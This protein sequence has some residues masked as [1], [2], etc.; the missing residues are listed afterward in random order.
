MEKI[1][2][3]INGELIAPKG[4][5]FREN[6]NPAIGKPFSLVPESNRDDFNLALKSAQAAYPIWSKLS[7]EERSDY[8][9][10]IANLIADKL[11]E[12]ALAEST[13]T[14]KPLSLA[15]RVDIPRASKNFK[16]FAQ[17][18]TQFGSESYSNTESINYTLRQPLGVVGCISPWNLPLYLFSWKIAPALAAGNCVIAKPSELTPYTAFLLSKICI[19]IGLPAGVLNI[20]H[21]TGASIGNEIVTSE[22]VKA[23]SFTGGTVTGKKIAEI[24]A[25]MLRKIS[26]ELGGKNAA[27]VFND[28][29]FDK[30]VDDLVR[31]SFTNQGEICLCASRIY[32]QEDIYE[33]FK[34]AFVERVKRLKVGDPRNA[35]TNM[36]ALISKDHLEKVKAFI[37]AAHHEGG[38]LLCGNE[39][40]ELKTQNEAGYYLRPHVFEGLSNSCKVNQQEVFGPLVTLQKFKSQEEGLSLVNDSSYGLATTLWTNDISKAH[41]LAAN[42]ESGIVW[43][44]CWM[45]RDLRTPFGGTKN[46]GLGREGGF[47]ALKFFTEQKNV[48]LAH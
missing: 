26:L 27:L 17:A 13:D 5:E 37:S 29:D 31:A 22:A 20:V 47:D 43:I 3:Y 33:E 48:C 10:A 30:T 14:G 2:N 23:I 40:I 46:S 38:K 34:T 21:G 8:L 7:N 1:L 42:I 35:S 24:S 28:C 18:I 36:G 25:P 41:S 32:I 19:E 11:D 12:L 9:L 6:I 4:G 44:N 16:F 15:K 39:S 45:N